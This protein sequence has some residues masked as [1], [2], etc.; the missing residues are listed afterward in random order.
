MDLAP[1]SLLV[2]ILTPHTRL[3]QITISEQLIHIYTFS[4]L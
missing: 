2:K 1:R 4:E 3:I